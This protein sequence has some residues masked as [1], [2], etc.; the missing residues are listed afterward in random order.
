MKN[1]KY[2]IIAIIS[3]VLTIIGFS[4]LVLRVH[5]TKEAEHLSYTWIFLILMSQSLLIIYGVINNLYGIYIPATILIVGVLSILYVK[6]YFN[7]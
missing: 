3:S 1:P 6:L 7:A 4:S 5:M 2:Q